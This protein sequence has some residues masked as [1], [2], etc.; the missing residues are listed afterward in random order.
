MLLHSGFYIHDPEK[1]EEWIK[2]I[3][4]KFRDLEKSKRKSISEFQYSNE[5]QDFKDKQWESFKKSLVKE[6]E[7]KKLLPDK[8]E[9]IIEQYKQLSECETVEDY[10][11]LLNKFS[12]EKL[13]EL[14]AYYKCDNLEE[15]L[16]YIETKLKPS[17]IIIKDKKIY[18]YLGGILTPEDIKYQDCF[19]ISNISEVPIKLEDCHSFEECEKRCQENNNVLSK[20]EKKKLLEFFNKYPDSIIRFNP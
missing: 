16:N 13:E 10:L 17:I 14:T 15:K 5:F 12:S 8:D 2:I 19:V 18:S 3:F 6:Y 9:S 11:Q 7:E 20:K 1:Q 4:N